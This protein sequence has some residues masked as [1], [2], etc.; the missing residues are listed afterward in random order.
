[1]VLKN[2]GTRCELANT[3]DTNTNELRGRFGDKSLHLKYHTMPGLDLRSKRV[4]ACLSLLLFV[5]SAMYLN[6]QS[7]HS[8]QQGMCAI[9]LNSSAC[10]TYVLHI[11]GEVVLFLVQLLHVVAIVSGDFSGAVPP[12]EFRGWA[13]R[14]GG[15][16]H[17]LAGKPPT[18]KTLI[19]ME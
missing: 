13:G 6:F 11:H 12:S 3:A 2:D 8:F 19:L 9:N 1:M 18:G 4:M 15:D 17:D 10:T 5:F 16:P 7:S 14:G